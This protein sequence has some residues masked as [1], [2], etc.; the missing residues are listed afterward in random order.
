MA[1]VTAV[2]PNGIARE[3]GIEI[4]DELLGFDE[5]PLTDILD[6]LYYDAQE[7]FVMHM[8]TAQGEDVDIEIEKDENETLG[9]TLDESAELE[10]MRCRNKCMFCFVDQLPSGMRDT[11]YVKDD[12]YR[13]S[14]VSGNYVT[15]TNVG[16]RELER[17]VRLHLSPLY[18]S[19]HCYDP[20]IK[21]KLIANPRGAELFE[22]MR[23]L[24]A[25]GIVMHAQIVMC[26]GINDAHE[27][28]ETLRQLA[29]M[30]PQVK[31]V[32]VI[33][34][35]LTAHRQGLA[36]LQPIDADCARDT[37][38]RTERLDREFGG[39]FC[40]CSDEFYIK[41]GLPL[42]SYERY[43]AFDQIENGVGLVAEFEHEFMQALQA[44]AG[45]A[46]RRDV[47]FVTGVSFAPILRGLL[48]RAADKF[49]GV[50][51]NVLAIR[52]KH[53]GESITVAGLVTAGDILDQIRRFAPHTVIPSTML[54]EFTDTFL[55]GMRLDELAQRAHTH[56]HVSHG[57]GDVIK[58]LEEVTE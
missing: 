28:E 39:G 29:E 5:Y 58:I 3:L 46:A 23:Y 34:V 1:K 48:D 2:Q 56:I 7:S 13:L 43:G 16:Q 24:A 4:G 55:D 53:F 6:Y 32:A 17:I 26:K 38:S 49:P 8:R 50:R 54:R 40:Y 42:P 11:L 9:M 36:Q 18:I 21:T 44:S 37:I 12:D 10:P 45:S 14:F 51:A 22:K 20:A 52:N 33:P 19:V 35:G 15:L 25:H 41:A 31:T 30:R 27:L 57:G 47:S